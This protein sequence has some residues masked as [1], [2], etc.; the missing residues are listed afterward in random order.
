MIQAARFC[1]EN[2][3]P[4]LGLC[5]GMQ[6][7]VIEFSKNV[8]NLSDANSTEFD[9]ETSNPVIDII[10]SQK[11]LEE[12]GGTMRL[13]GYRCNLSSGTLAKKIYQK[14]IITERHRHRYEFND[15]Y[16]EKLNSIGFI[17]S[18][19]CPA[20]NL[21]EISEISDHPFMIGSQFHPEFGSRLDRP[22]PLFD[23]FIKASANQKK[24]GAQF[25]L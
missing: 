4:Y 10:E 25:Q 13:G 17:T 15:Y 16:K 18:G 12:T 1:R 11:G 24:T 21:V 14:D 5:L 9:P 23:H 22:H 20:N 19:E 6:I 8:L 7:M 2:Q 3:L